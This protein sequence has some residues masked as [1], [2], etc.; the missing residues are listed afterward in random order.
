LFSLAVVL[1]HD[2]QFFSA[3]FFNLFS[4]WWCMD[5]HK[6][7][8][9]AQQPKA[10]TWRYSKRGGSFQG[11]L[12]LFLGCWFGRHTCCST[13]TQ[14]QLARPGVPLNALERLSPLCHY[15][16]LQVWGESLVCD[17]LCA[18]FLHISAIPMFEL[19]GWCSV[20]ARAQAFK[21]SCPVFYS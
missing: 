17:F 2:L 19:L 11:V 15:N 10:S 16:L 3:A 4:N 5:H 14:G 20:V 8:S 1:G 12:F 6:R 9:T 13:T 18:R 21:K 7:L